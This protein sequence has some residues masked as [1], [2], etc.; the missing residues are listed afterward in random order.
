M[1]FNNSLLIQGHEIKPV[2]CWW[3]LQDAQN[4]PP[5]DKTNK[6]ACAPSEDS[7]QPGHLPSMIRVPAVR[8]KKAHVL[9]CLLS[10]HRRLIRLGGCPSW[11]ESLLDAQIILL[12][13]SRGSSNLFVRVQC[14][15]QQFFSHIMT[16][17]GCDRELNA[18][19]YS[20]ASLTYHA[21]NT[22]HDTTPSHIILTLG[23]PV[24]ALPRKPVCQV[25]SS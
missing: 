18:H 7:D 16:V 3:I 20:A 14:C 10:T 9:S 15:F 4:E 24:L 11:S 2:Y 21:P 5:Y 23:R 17:S 6:T 8:M 25:R 12:V 19:F 22:W 1:L 13:L